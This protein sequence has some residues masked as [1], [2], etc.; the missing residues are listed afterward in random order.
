MSKV[1]KWKN[2]RQ[3]KKRE[4]IYEN[5]TEKNQRQ[6]TKKNGDGEIIFKNKNK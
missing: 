1:K 6:R 5:A 4:E 3:K 2:F